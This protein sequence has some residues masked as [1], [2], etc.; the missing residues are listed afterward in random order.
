MTHAF[1]VKMAEAWLRTRGYRIVLSEQTANPHEVPDVIGWKADC[2]S[3]VVECKVSRSDFFAD[4][5][6]TARVKPE[7]AMGCERYYL[8]PNNMVHP[9]ELRGGWGLLEVHNK[10]VALR[11]KCTPRPQRAERGLIAEMELLLASLRRVEIRIEPQTITEFLKWKNR[12]IAYNGGQ[13][14]TGLAPP[15]QEL[16]S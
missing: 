1:L 15:E 7:R 4:Q 3:L 11:T 16:F 14:P 8:T 2:Y 9:G 6:K 12:L 5:K 13:L 10:E